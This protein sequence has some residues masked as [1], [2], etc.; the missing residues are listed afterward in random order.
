MLGENILR[1]FG[2]NFTKSLHCSFNVTKGK[3]FLKVVFY[4]K[5]SY[6]LQQGLQHKISLPMFFSSLASCEDTMLVYV[7]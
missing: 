6:S 4:I 7:L 2:E 3:I 5:M 1:P